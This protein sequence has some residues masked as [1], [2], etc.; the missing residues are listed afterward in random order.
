MDIPVLTMPCLQVSQANVSIDLGDLCWGQC[1][2]TF[3]PACATV[4]RLR[5][6]ESSTISASKVKG[7]KENHVG[8]GIE[9]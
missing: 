1:G 9:Q 2:M 8:Q 4:F 6:G 3:G 7:V 5:A